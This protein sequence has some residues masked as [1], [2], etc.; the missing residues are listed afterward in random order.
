MN[1]TIQTGNVGRDPEVHVT[2]NGKKV[3]NFS[4][5]NTR[6]SAGQKVTDWHSIVCWEKLADVVESYVKKGDRL[7]V[8][9][10]IQYRKFT[11]KD[12]NERQVTEIK[13]DEVE[14]SPKREQSGST[15]FDDDDGEVP[16]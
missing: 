10:R 16:F 3:A 15:S 12:G 6:P 1:I 4:L 13:A 7:L 14:L 11:D 2:P 9:G 5:A 8:R